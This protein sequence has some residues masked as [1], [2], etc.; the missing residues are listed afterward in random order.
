MRAVFVLVSAALVLPFVALAVA[1]ASAPD[2]A[3]WSVHAVELFALVRSLVV[4]AAAAVLATITGVGLAFQVS[5]CAFP[6][7]R[8]IERASV[9]PLLFPAFVLAAVYDR[10]LGGLVGSGVALVAVLALGSFPY[11]YLLARLAFV[12]HGQ[13]FVELGTGLGLDFA[14]TFARVLLPLAVP[15]VVLGS[16]LV[17][18]EGAGAWAAPSFLSVATTGPVIHGLWFA[19]AAP[20]LAVQLALVFVLIAALALGPL[21]RWASSL[22]ARHLVASASAPPVRRA[23]P[24]PWLRLILCALP[25]T[26]G[27]VVP[28]LAVIGMMARTVGTIDLSQ[29]FSSAVASVVL[30]VAV[31]AGCVAVA[32]VVGVMHRSPVAAWLVRWSAVSYVV[33]PTVVAVGFLVALEVVP[34]LERYGDLSASAILVVALVVRLAPFVLLPLWAGISSAGDSLGE[35]GAAAG[36]GPARRFVRLHLP[37]ARGFV[38]VGALLVAV[39][40]LKETAVSVILHPFSVQPL[41]VKA[42]AYIDI[43]L[44]PESSAWILAG[45]VLGAYP[46]LTLESMLSRRS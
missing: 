25:V 46:L 36:L 31:A 12:R 4:G 42:R 44:L 20:E 35:V 29:L 2:L 16:V 26:F 23:A 18:V 6:G 30:V 14:R 5:F 15:A 43:D 32:A 7:R 24:R 9:L 28:A 10:L 45:L 17:F 33:P 11:V 41:V 8:W 13:G 34:C 37:H 38:L 22:G 1:A 3:A 40:T 27:F 21:G 19:R 39:Q